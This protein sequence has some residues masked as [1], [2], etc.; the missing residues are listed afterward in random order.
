MDWASATKKLIVAVVGLGVLALKQYFGIDLGG[1]A[2]TIA[3]AAITILTSLGVF[4]VGQPA[5]PAK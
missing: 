2:D 4:T 1:M 5:A 3:D